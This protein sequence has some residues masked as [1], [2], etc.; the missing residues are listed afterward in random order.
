VGC[1]V[2]LGPIVVGLSDYSPD[3]L[4]M[5]A[6]ALLGGAMFGDNLSLISDT[7]IAA[8][9]V[10]DCKMKDKF[11]ANFKLAF[12]AAI[13]TIIVVYFIQPQNSEII[14]MS[15]SNQYYLLIPYL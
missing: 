7:T 6:G 14:E 3:S 5:L 4:P 13:L 1:I 2:A 15:H 11:L 12:I 9:Q 10:M 8:T